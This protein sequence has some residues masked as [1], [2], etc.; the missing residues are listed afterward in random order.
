MHI[1]HFYQLDELLIESDSPI[2]AD[3]VLRQRSS[4]STIIPVRSCAL[5]FAC[6]TAR[7]G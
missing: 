6:T 7:R 5:R 2:D 3:G 4:R 1:A